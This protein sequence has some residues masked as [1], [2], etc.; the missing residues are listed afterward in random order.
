MPA[1]RNALT[2]KLFWELT[3]RLAVADGAAL[4]LLGPGGGLA[5]PAKRARFRLAPDEQRRLANLPENERL[6]SNLEA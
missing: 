1:S 4:R 2:S 5:A 6:V 3:D